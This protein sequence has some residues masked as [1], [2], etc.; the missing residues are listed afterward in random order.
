MLKRSISLAMGLLL[1]GVSLLYGLSAVLA[2]GLD[3]VSPYFPADRIPLPPDSRVI[4]IANDFESVEDD[5]SCWETTT[6]ELAMTKSEAIDYFSPLLNRGEV[7]HFVVSGDTSD[8]I[9]WE[10]L[11]DYPEIGNYVELYAWYNHLLD[12]AKI[13]IIKVLLFTTAE[14]QETIVL[15]WIQVEYASKPTPNPSAESHPEEPATDLKTESLK[16]AALDAGCEVFD[17]WT[18]GVFTA[19]SPAGGFDMRYED[20]F[21]SVLEFFTA[22]EARDFMDEQQ[23]HAYEYYSDGRFVAVAMEG[24]FEDAPAAYEWL[25]EL[26]AG[27]Q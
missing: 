21:V 24:T 18:Y 13:S 26:L 5:A 3:G 12:S 19:F 15:A 8:Y 22:G 4:G 2:E 16:Q 14:D 25:G 9:P 17:D 1:I 7:N 27:A 23:G 6:L 11:N 20:A 10:V